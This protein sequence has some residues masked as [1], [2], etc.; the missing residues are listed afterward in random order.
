MTQTIAGFFRTRNEGETAQTALHSAGFPA[1]SVSFL[2]GDTRGHQTPELGPINHVEGGAAL[3]QDA[4]LGSAIGLA[5][6]MIA[7]FIPGIGPL[8][9]AGP[10]GGAI[11]GLSVGAGAGG[12]LGLLKDHGVSDEEAEF[13]AEGVRR[14]GALVTVECRNED[15]EKRARDI[16]RQ[17]GALDT[18]DLSV[19]SR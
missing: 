6:G 12:L 8:I 14:G 2:A 10:I 16:L 15:E 13:F 9:A 5:V 7:V 3:A 11:T 17:R 19:E 18:E 1:D 4:F